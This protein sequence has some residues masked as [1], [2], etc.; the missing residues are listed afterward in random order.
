MPKFL[1]AKLKRQYGADSKIPFKV[2]N[3]MGVMRGNKVTPKG[4][5]MEEK[6]EADLS[7][8]TQRNNKKS[9][10]MKL[11]STYMKEAK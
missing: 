9:A 6:H 11:H 3:K 7:E 4:V 10:R 2:M 8:G 1:E 5:A